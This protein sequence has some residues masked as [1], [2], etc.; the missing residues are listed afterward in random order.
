MTPQTNPWIV[1]PWANEGACGYLYLRK[2]AEKKTDSEPTEVQKRIFSV[3]LSPFAHL[4]LLQSMAERSRSPNGRGATGKKILITGSPL[5]K[6][7]GC[8]ER[9]KCLAERVSIQLPCRLGTRR[10]YGICFNT[11]KLKDRE[12]P[13]STKPKEPGGHCHP[14][15]FGQLRMKSFLHA[16]WKKFVCMMSTYETTVCP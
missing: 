8:V 1:G 7:R 11:Q 4:N 10:V 12:R 2:N 15:V 16:A 14:W 6:Q 13:I 9:A 5:E 3:S